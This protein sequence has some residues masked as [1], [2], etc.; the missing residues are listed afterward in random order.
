MIAKKI[1]RGDVQEFRELLSSGEVSIAVVGLGRIGLPTAAMFA[2]AGARVKGVDINSKLVEAI[3]SKKNV[4]VDEPGLYEVLNEVISKGRLEATLDSASA[5]AGSDFIIV[6]VPTPVLSTK[7]PDYSF[8]ISACS[9]IGRHMSRG[10]IV[11]IESTVGPGTV[12]QLILPVLEKE[13][14]LKAEVGFGVASCPERSDPG[15]ILPNIK[16]LPRVVGGM[17]KRTT[18]LVA[19]LYEA[20]L[21]TKVIKVNNPRT[22]NAVKLTENLFRDVNIALMNEFALLYEKLGIDIIEVINACST[23]YNFMPHYPGPGVGGP[24]LPSNSYYLIEEGIKVGNIPYLIRMAR[25]I[26]DRMPEHAVELVFE[27]LNAV[28]KT[29]SGSRICVLGI[30][31]KPNV[32]DVQLTP[33]E[34]ICQRLKDMGAEI[35][36]YDPMYAG[37]RALGFYVEKELKDAIAGTD[38]ILVGTAH[39]QFKQIR[40]DELVRFMNKNPAV[41]DTRSLFSP[42]DAKKAGFSYRGIGRPKF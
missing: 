11:I 9:N 2:K 29:V 40:L 32:K 15:N 24:C 22:A 4:F 1:S 14:G 23:K 20:A 38:C 10:S 30:S 7:V 31:Y 8:V 5:I 28:G 36:I 26:N 6:S 13:S 21:G 39:D 16:S 25:E 42:E 3:N 41:V 33:V 18:D 37:E 19:S 34:R 12:E 27:A 35:K 17:D